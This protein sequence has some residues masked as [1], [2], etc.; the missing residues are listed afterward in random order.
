M[1]T[2]PSGTSVK[3]NVMLPSVPLQ[4]VGFVPI[5]ARVGIGGSVNVISTSSIEAQLF[6]LIVRLLY[7]PSVNPKNE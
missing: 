1:V 2:F 7:S 4:V 6:T 3:V 5:A